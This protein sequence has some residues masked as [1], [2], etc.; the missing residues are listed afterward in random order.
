[1]ASYNGDVSANNNNTPSSSRPMSSM[2]PVVQRQHAGGGG[3]SHAPPIRATWTDFCEHHAASAAD[4]FAWNVGQ[5]VQENSV[6]V[7]QNFAQKYT[8]YFLLHFDAHLVPKRSLHTGASIVGTSNTSQVATKGAASAL[9]RSKTT[10][11]VT[12]S[13][14]QSPFGSPSKSTHN[15]ASTTRPQTSSFRSLRSVE[16]NEPSIAS[17][18]LDLATDSLQ[19][20][21]LSASEKISPTKHVSFLRRFSLR[22][23]VRSSMRPL[24]QLFKQQSDEMELANGGTEPDVPSALVANGD[25]CVAK[26]RT[27]TTSKIKTTKIVVECLREGLVSV[28]TDDKSNGQ[29]KWDKCRLALLKT[30][31]GDLLEFYSP[32]KVSRVGTTS[33]L[34]LC[35]PTSTNKLDIS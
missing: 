30:A 11:G 19:S 32:P 7:G 14:P 1:M 10:V 9:N 18:H 29:A 20:N 17:I 5:Y 12:S 26:Q 13:V 8:E 24:R 22:R 35:G 23:S 25:K 33:L 15:S 6:H 31:G 3:S 34:D 2:S 27:G 16:T 21:S 4:E 28:L